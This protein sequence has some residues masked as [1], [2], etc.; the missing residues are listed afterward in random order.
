M[1]KKCSS[2]NFYNNNIFSYGPLPNTSNLT[3]LNKKIIKKFFTL[4]ECKSCGLIQQT[5]L[6]KLSFI[7]KNNSNKEENSHHPNLIEKLIKNKIIKINHKILFISNYDKQFFNLLKKKGFE[8]LYFL[9][10]KKDFK[11]KFSNLNQEII[12]KYLN[13]KNSNFINDKY[14]KF[15]FI[16]CSSILDHARNLKKVCS[17]FANLM[18]ENGI[19]G[20]EVPDN[21]KHLKSGN[22]LMIWEEHNFYFTEKSS[23]NCFNNFGFNNIKRYTFEYLQENFIFN[24]YK[25]S[26]KKKYNY[27]CKNLVNDFNMKYF[28]Y[29]NLSNLFIKKFIYQYK[30]VIFGAGHNSVKFIYLYNLQNVIDFVIDSNKKKI[31]KYI[32]GTTIKVINFQNLIKETKNEKILFM[33]SANINNEKKIIND[34][35]N[36]TLNDVK[37]FS[38]YPKSKLFFLNKY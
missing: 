21:L 29:L 12:Q 34:L 22:I 8:N 25:K 14:G 7:E 31:N 1:K 30:L 4:F 37:F 38:I 20:I 23:K 9:D 19:L 17:F 13:K 36:N 32:P 24:L 15:D 10:Y 26:N 28:E 33:I 3:N 11:V 5:N 2:C 18:N 35:K 16:F 6:P 27:T